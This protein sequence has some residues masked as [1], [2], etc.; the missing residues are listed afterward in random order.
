MAVSY[1]LVFL[2]VALGVL[3]ASIFFADIRNTRRLK[4]LRDARL[5]QDAEVADERARAFHEKFGDGTR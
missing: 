5:R 1:L 3:V 2:L 4:H